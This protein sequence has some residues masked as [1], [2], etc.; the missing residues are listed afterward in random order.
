MDHARVLTHSSYTID[1]RRRSR[2]PRE[3]AVLAESVRFRATADGLAVGNLYYA[4]PLLD[5][6]GRTFGVS[7]AGASLI[8]TVTQFGYAA[9]LVFIAPLADLLENRRLIATVL[10]GTVL[11]RGGFGL[12]ACGMAGNRRYRRGSTARGVRS[13]GSPMCALRYRSRRARTL[14]TPTGH[15]SAARR[16][17]RQALPAGAAFAVQMGESVSSAIATQVGFSPTA[18]RSRAASAPNDGSIP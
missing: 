13:F 11:S 18:W 12:R 7:E 16:V 15:R 1:A 6:I 17:S 9:G 3:Q 14:A 4:Q 10:C 8:V 5:T 2:Q